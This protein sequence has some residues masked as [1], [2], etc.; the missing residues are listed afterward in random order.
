VT[1][2]WTFLTKHAAVLLVLSADPDATLNDIAAGA[3][4]SHRWTVKVVNDLLG[5]GY[6]TRK[7]TG[8]SYTYVIDTTAPLRLDLVHHADVERLTSLLEH[9]GDD[10][11]RATHRHE[12]AA[13][14]RTL[15][16]EIGREQR[17]LQ[18]L[19]KTRVQLEDALTTAQAA[20][21]TINNNAPHT[22]RP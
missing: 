19:T 13:Q 16:S 8:R 3:A 6:V 7:R 11:A 9:S 2:G 20:L 22:P 15:R 5:A 14:L 12:L 1:D 10:S 4:L 18:Q 21:A 17:H